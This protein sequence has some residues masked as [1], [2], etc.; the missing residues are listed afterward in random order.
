MSKRIKHIN[1]S[2]GRSCFTH[3]TGCYQFFGKQSVP[4]ATEHLLSFLSRF[5]NTAV[6]SV[7]F[8]G[9]DPLSRPDILALLAGTAALGFRI[10]L[11]TVGTPLIG[12]AQTIFY[13]TYDVP[14]I[15]PE[16]IKPYVHR[17]GLPL[18]GSTDAMATTFRRG[19][20]NIV[21]EQ[22]AI[23]SATEAAGIPTVINTVVSAQNADD[24]LCLAELIRPFSHIVE[25][26]LF[27]F[28][29]IGKLG[30]RNRA[31]FLITEDQFEQVIGRLRVAQY[32]WKWPIN[33]VPKT[34]AS[35]KGLYCLVDTDGL[36][37]RPA[38]GEG[39]DWLPEKD[40][41][42]DRIILGDIRIPAD[43]ARIAAFILGDVQQVPIGRRE[44]LPLPLFS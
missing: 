7:T 32:H 39:A 31:N 35:R 12:D 26:Q 14:H 23:L 10:N 43:A 16:M 6:E 4:I 41:T 17:L 1:I 19:R 36:A 34:C 22:L 20:P 5:I 28:M 15:S 2:A 11:D 42:E 9:G 30:F 44:M 40:E 25:W 38:F 8:A 3:C 21:S 37:W 27:Q 33:L 13:G 29:P 24:L 18:D